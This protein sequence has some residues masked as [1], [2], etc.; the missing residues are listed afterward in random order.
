MLTTALL[1]LY[2]MAVSGPSIRAG[3][4]QDS[5]V[6]ETAAW[7]AELEEMLKIDEGWLTLAGL[8][9]L[10]NPCTIGFAPDPKGGAK[11][12][13]PNAAGIWGV[14]SRTGDKVEL[15][16]A[17]GHQVRV[18]QSVVDHTILKSDNELN[19]DKVT[20]GSIK[21]MLIQR[22]SRLG[23]RIWDTENPNRKHFS[24]QKWYPIDSKYRVQAQYHAYAK[25][26]DMPITNVLGDTA[27][28]PNPGYV[29]FVLNGKKCHLEAQSEGE[30]LFFNFKDLTSGKSTYAAGRFLNAPGPKGGIVVIDFNR[31]INP[32]CA[33]TDFATCPLPPKENTL[34][35][36]VRAGEKLYP[37][38][39][40]N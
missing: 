38:D 26:K 37:R 11:F 16:V 32:P 1:G 13:E 17:A 21:M 7:R 28:V 22:G 36:E 29:E 2:A 10:E 35:V 39:H 20:F 5:Y 24:G 30:G 12:P 31:A 33:F 40:R 4:A 23:L 18:N 25:P 6:K 15:R 8:Q 9:W 34:S 19:P 27:M 3:Q 14:I